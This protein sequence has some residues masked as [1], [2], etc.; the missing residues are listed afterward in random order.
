MRSISHYLS[1]TFGG[2]PWWAEEFHF[3]GQNSMFLEKPKRWLARRKKMSASLEKRKINLGNDWWKVAFQNVPE[4]V[5]IFWSPLLT[6]SDED[7]LQHFTRGKLVI[8]CWWGNDVGDVGFLLFWIHI[9]PVLSGESSSSQRIKD[10]VCG[11]VFSL[12][13]GSQFLDRKGERRRSTMRKDQ[14][15][16]GVYF[17]WKKTRLF[18]ISCR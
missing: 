16:W 15:T 10:L 9:S 5:N 7:F 18:R 13:F 4:L 17:V 8:L 6:S 3:G 11:G 12:F 2:H 14:R 1:P